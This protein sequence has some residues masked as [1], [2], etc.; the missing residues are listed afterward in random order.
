MR[1]PIS[2][3][4]SPPTGHFKPNSR[5]HPATI[6]ETIVLVDETTPLR[7]GAIG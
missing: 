1:D 5:K 6:N 7:M 2:F 4:L 3:L